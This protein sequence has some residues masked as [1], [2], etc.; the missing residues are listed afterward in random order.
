MR[1][2]E[3]S[4]N[5]RRSSSGVKRRRITILAPQRGQRHKAEG[6]G[7]RSVETATMGSAPRNWR[8]SASIRVRL[9]SR[10]LPCA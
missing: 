10:G 8:A 3:E 7:T 5:N 4:K 6:C 1:H 2:H 9:G